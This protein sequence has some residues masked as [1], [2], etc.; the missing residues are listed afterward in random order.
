MTNPEFHHD[1][2]TRMPI[3]Q[4]IHLDAF[5]KILVDA[6]LPLDT[7]G[8]GPAKTVHHLFK[9]VQEGESMMSVDA[10]GNV[11]REVSV[12]WVDVFCSLSNGDLYRLTEDRQVFK[13]GRKDNVK[14]RTLSTSLGEKLKPGEDPAEAVERAIAEELGIED[15]LET[16]HF[17][18]TEDAEHTPDT[19]PGLK[20]FYH[21]FKYAAVISETA[22]NPE[23]YIEDQS[24]KTNYY[25]WEKIAEGVVSGNSQFS[26]E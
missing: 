24:D 26:A 23:G 13:D 9:E 4:D 18:G 3:P 14:R 25:V 1:Q 10:K 12:L 16:V 8:E 7:Y 17:V 20:S 19:Y 6:K 2:D 22:F 11:T 15:G 5:L 21:N